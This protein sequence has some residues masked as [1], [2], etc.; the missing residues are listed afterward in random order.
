MALAP[1]SEIFIRYV[2]HPV[3][4]RRYLIAHAAN[5]DWFV[6]TPDGDIYEETLSR[7]DPAISEL[8]ACPGPGRLPPGLP[9]NRHDWN[10]GGLPALSDAVRIA[11]MVAG[12]AELSLHYGPAA[13]GIA[14]AAAELARLQALGGGAGGA[15][16]PV[17]AAPGVGAVAAAQRWRVVRSPT[18]APAF[19]E[20]VDPGT[21]THFQ[22]TLGMATVAGAVVQVELVTDDHLDVWKAECRPLDARILPA[23]VLP[24]GKR[25]RRFGDAVAMVSEEAFGDWP[26]AGPRTTLWCLQFLARTNQGALEHHYKWKQLSKLQ[27]HDYGVEFHEAVMR[28]V[29]LAV[30]YDQVDSTNL[31][32]LEVALRRAQIIEYYHMQRL[33]DGEHALPNA[34]RLTMDEVTAFSGVRRQDDNLMLCPALIDHAR[35]E[36]SKIME[37]NKSMRKH[38][39]EIRLQRSNGRDDKGGKKKKKDDSE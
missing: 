16:V 30:T 7:H 5:A 2:G 17:V 27:V 19:G 6:A 20:I 15:P 38:R 1:G 29:E 32:A 13:P 35:D 25:G 18:G 37:I 11:Y 26:V 4:H 21:V 12:I 34:S 23:A 10:A 3:C 9:A 31:S 24:G 39:E 33:R 22:G 28:I 14:L 8:W 36:V